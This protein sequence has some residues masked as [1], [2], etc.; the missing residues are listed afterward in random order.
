MMTVP[1]GVVY[2][3]L[4][5]FVNSLAV[6]LGWYY[7]CQTTLRCDVKTGFQKKGGETG[8][9]VIFRP[10]LALGG[11]WYPPP[12]H[13]CTQLHRGWAEE[14]FFR[15]IFAHKKSKKKIFFFDSPVSVRAV[16]GSFR[17]QK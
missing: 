9:W 1:T 15:P 10:M 14:K 11:G 4:F 6:F 16:M 12:P 3:G 17:A 2:R 13:L 8:L 5:L 7:E